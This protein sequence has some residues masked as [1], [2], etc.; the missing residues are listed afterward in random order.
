MSNLEQTLIQ[1]EKLRRLGVNIAIDDFGTG[2]SSLSY[3]RQLPVDTLKIDRSFIDDI[4]SS[5][6]N[7]RQLI[8]AVVGMAH[9][10]DLRVVAEGVETERQYEVTKTAGCDLSQ[11]YFHYKAM[12]AGALGEVLADERVKAGLIQLSS[13]LHVARE[14]SADCH[15]SPAIVG[16]HADLV[17]HIYQAE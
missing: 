12:S 17:D 14:N 4:D 13:A 16:S 6:G 5:C 1:F 3:L 15:G 10:L 11:G 9:G 7:T 2:N 8:R